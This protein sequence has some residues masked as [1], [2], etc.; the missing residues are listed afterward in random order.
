[1]WLYPGAAAWHFITLPKKHSDKIRVVAFDAKSAWGSIR[2][3]ATIGKTTWKTSIFPDKKADSY[4]FPI[5]T[6][7]RKKERLAAG[8][9]VAVVIELDG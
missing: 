4:L 8:D 7:V 3:I 6:D 2:V 1:M 9:E 5:K